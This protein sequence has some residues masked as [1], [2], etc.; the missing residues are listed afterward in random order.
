MAHIN[1][2]EF[3]AL[4]EGVK[5]RPLLRKAQLPP[6]QTGVPLT[7]VLDSY[8]AMAA[9]HRDQG[10]L[11]AQDYADLDAAVNALK[12]VLG[13]INDSALVAEAAARNA[14]DL[15]QKLKAKTG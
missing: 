3:E 1:A 6:A 13:R 2:A 4:W 11:S 14:A 8:L 5:E 7:K 10:K 12:A 9:G 15:E